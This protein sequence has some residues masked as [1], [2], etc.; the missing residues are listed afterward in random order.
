MEFNQFHF[1]QGAWLWGLLAIPVVPIL[2]SLFHKTQSAG[3][4]E[5]FADRHLLPHLV[6]SRGVAGNNIRT[7]L[8]LWSAA[9]FF[10]VIA[11]AGPRWNYTD[12]QTF[13]SAQDLVI[14]LDLSQ[15]MNA[16]DVKPSRI[17][18]AR[19]EIEDLLDMSR[20][21]S[22][23]L[24]A[25][26]EVPH[27]VTPLTD[28]VRTIKNL[29]PE[30]D[31]SLITIQGD[32][33][34]PA[35]ELA[36][37][38]LKGEPGNDKSVLVISDGNF[39]ENDFPAL[40]HAAGN[41][42]IYT[43][44]IGT[45]SGAPMPGG[46]GGQISRLRAVRL[47]S[48]AAAGHGLYVEANYTNDDTRAILSRIDAA[49][50]K[51]L[52]T[53]KT[54]RLWQER[55]YI[56]ALVLALLLLPLFRR[57]AV[58]PIVILFSTFLFLPGHAQAMTL[59]DLFLNKEQQASAAYNHHNYKDAKFDTP[60]RQGVVAYRQG[61]YDKAAMLFKTAAAQTGNT[62]AVYNLGNAQL[63][64]YLPEDAI[65]SY[66]TVLKK[67]P[68]DVPTLHNLAI[69]EKMLEKQKQPP[70]PQQKP[71]KPPKNNQGGGGGGG[72]GGGSGG[73]QNK[74]QGQQ[75]QGKNG[76]QNAQNQ[77]RG[78]RNQ[79][80]AGKQGSQNKQ[81]AG[82]SKGN[83]QAAQQPARQQQGGQGQAKQQ[84]G[85]QGGK[86]A[87]AK[88]QA[89]RVNPGSEKNPGNPSANRYVLVKARDGAP[90]TQLDI[91]ADE[92]L[93]R[94]QSDPGSFL[95]N[96]FMIEEQQSVQKQGAP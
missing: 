5:R 55:F 17:G 27:M 84:A 4:L 32:R 94:V 92:W 20:G 45:A 76:Q 11:M 21:L 96:Q 40:A 82:Q 77:Q 95:K 18:R 50:T 51:A 71:P 43:M 53:P 65:A 61:A 93:N 54:V 25:Y 15:S 67:K 75:Q 36:A 87:A 52:T 6:K 88:L 38:M 58:F 35:L 86:Q 49:R 46:D 37:I 1:A 91:N 56:P 13:A 89:A 66:K 90:R 70:Q 73:G 2:Y 24:V 83:Q 85:Q 59:S 78:A 80:Q 10:G 22:I 28:D 57:G 3:L 41:A 69:A 30:L 7:S 14:V 68:G 19:E 64:Q 63:M 9:W 81:Q 79:S 16:K 39:Q 42:T 31:T 48:L 74:Q 47:Q 8:L 23:G 26:A 44:G 62:D 29:L 72:G 33:L 60:Y 12:Q 34:E